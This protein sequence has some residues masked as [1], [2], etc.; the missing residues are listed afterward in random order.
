MHPSQPVAERNASLHEPPVESEF[1]FQWHV[2]ERC[3]WR[4]RHC[5]HTS[6]DSAGEFSEEQLLEVACRIEAAL[7]VWGKEGAVSLTGGEPWLRSGA[8]LKILAHFSI[9]GRVRRVD[10]LTNGALLDDDA[11]V[12]LAKSP[13]LRRV[14]LSV[15]GSSAATHDLIRGAGSF[16]ETE[17]AVRRLKRH[18]ITVAVMITLS[19]HNAGDVIAIFERLMSWGVDTVAVD[20]FIPE[21]RAAE[22]THWVLSADEIK[23]VFGRIHAWGISHGSPRVLMYRPLFCLIEEDSPHVGA[24]CS[25]GINALTILHDGTIYPCRRLPIKLGNVLTDSLHD[26]WYASPMLWK[27]RVPSNLK[28]RCAAC[29]H[30]PSCRGCRAMALAV[31]GDWLG[32]D[33]QCWME[34]DCLPV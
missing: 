22:Q 3:N 19:R 32:E 27:A 10:L 34:A 5:Y 8:I 17:Q 13:V 12:Q 21:G 6:Y 2:T 28:G 24:M 26:I 7:A 1:Y 9:G 23:E 16:H 11:C 25:V 18:G 20:R 29:R 33:P 4:C 30:V 31:S 15:E 14:Q